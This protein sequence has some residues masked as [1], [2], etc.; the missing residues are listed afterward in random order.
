MILCRTVYI[1]LYMIQARYLAR[2]I[3]RYLPTGYNIMRLHYN[4]RY[5]IAH[6]KVHIRS[7]DY[8][9]MVCVKWMTYTK[10]VYILRVFIQ[11]VPYVN[12]LKINE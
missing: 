1:I 11:Q 12:R 7:H 10:A 6:N 3:P 5:T 2:T 9:K 8:V 4:T